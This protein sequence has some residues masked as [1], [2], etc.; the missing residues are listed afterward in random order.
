MLAEGPFG[1]FTAAARRRE[2]LLL[3]AGGI[4][5]TPV[6]ALLEESP[7]D[8]VVLYRAID[9]GRPRLP[10]RAR[11]AR[12]PRA[13]SRSTSSSATTAPTRARGLLSA[14]HLHEL[15]PDLAERDVYVCGPP[16]LADFLKREVRRAGVPRR[17]LHTERFAL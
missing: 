17:H 15:V 12:A 11:G 16:G 9:R 13:A 3:V 7:G 10:R 1:V 5:I 2:K 14:E 6:R 8:V 4:G